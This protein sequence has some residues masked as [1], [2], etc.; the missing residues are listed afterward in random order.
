MGPMPPPTPMW[1]QFGPH[2]HSVK[3]DSPMRPASCTWR[4]ITSH[5]SP[6][7]ARQARTRRSRVRRTPGSSS[8][9]RRP[10]LAGIQQWARRRGGAVARLARSRGARAGDAAGS[11]ILRS[12]QSLQALLAIRIEAEALALGAARRLIGIGGGA[13]FG[14]HRSRRDRCGNPVSH[15]AITEAGPPRDDTAA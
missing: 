3:S 14:V 13:L 6:C 7:W 10:R 2:A 5:S 8:A 1:Q 11:F 4:N 9:W 12:A 15:H